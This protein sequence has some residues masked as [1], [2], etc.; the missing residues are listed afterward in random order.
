MRTSKRYRRPLN[1]AKWAMLAQIA[2]TY[3][4]EKNLHLSYYNIDHNFIQDKSHLD[5]QMRNV[6]AG[7]A[8]PNGL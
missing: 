7:Y 3:R 6:R 1:R 8:S 5:Q 4:A 2:R